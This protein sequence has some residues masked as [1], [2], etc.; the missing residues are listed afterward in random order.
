[1][2][3]RPADQRPLASSAA[4]PVPRPPRLDGLRIL[5]VD[6]H[7]DGRALTSLVLTEAGASVNAVAS[8]GEALQVLDVERPD[9][10][11]S[12]IALSDDDGYALIREIR[13]HEA[14]HGGFIPAIALTGFARLED[15]ALSLAAGFQAHVLKPVEPSDLVTTVATFAHHPGDSDR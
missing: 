8:V 15:Q 14:K 3:E 6:D 1:V 12:D 2:Q 10:L 5:V 13:Q 4:P 11:V 7:A 9:A